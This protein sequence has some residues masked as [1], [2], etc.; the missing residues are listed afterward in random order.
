[1]ARIGALSDLKCRSSTAQVQSH[2]W[3]GLA[4]IARMLNIC[5]TISNNVPNIL[6]II[7]KPSQKWIPNSTNQL[8][9]P[10]LI[11]IPTYALHVHT[12]VCLAVYLLKEW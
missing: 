7:A 6:A 8:H 10:G 2:F 5:N 11:A 4:T 9:P 3:A 12:L 1:M